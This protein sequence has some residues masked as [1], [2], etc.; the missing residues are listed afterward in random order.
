MK[1]RTVYQKV[2][3]LPKAKAFWSAFLG[4]APVKD[5]PNWCAFSLENLNFALLLNDFDDLAAGSNAVPVF[6][7]SKDEMTDWVE[8][9][10]GLGCSVIFD[11]LADIKMGSIVLQDPNG[12]EFEL[13]FPHE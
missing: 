2:K 12:H 4:Q 9:A 1:V 7:V 13:S 10:R 8:K 3:D 5:L 6:E 11:G